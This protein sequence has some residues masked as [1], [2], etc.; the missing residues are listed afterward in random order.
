MGPLHWRHHYT[1]YSTDPITWKPISQ[2]R[3]RHCSGVKLVRIDDKDYVGKHQS[4][5][6]RPFEVKDLKAALGPEQGRAKVLAYVCG[7][8]R[9]NGWAVDVLKGSVGMDEKRVLWEERW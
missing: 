2:L 6:N 4:V 9:M 3:K 5:E 8:P 1:I 7:P